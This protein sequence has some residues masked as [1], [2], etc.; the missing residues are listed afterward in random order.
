MDSSLSL[1]GSPSSH[2]ICTPELRREL[3]PIARAKKR[4]KKPTLNSYSR[5][6][7]SGLKQQQHMQYQVHGDGS[8][9]YTR[10]YVQPPK[11]AQPAPRPDPPAHI[12]QN[13]SAM[14]LDE[15]SEFSHDLSW[16]ADDGAQRLGRQHRLGV[17]R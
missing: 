1:A 11:N 14:L 13:D 2:I 16:D 7:P 6:K 9:S 12:Q 10:R 5:P 4:Q 15:F 17:S 8:I 3:L